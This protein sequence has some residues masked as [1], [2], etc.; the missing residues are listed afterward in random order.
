MSQL[1]V[2]RINDASGGVLAPISS[3]MRNRLINGAMTINQRGGAVTLPS[4]QTYTLDRWFGSEDTDGAMTVEQSTNAPTGFN[5]SALCTTTTA[6]SSLGATQNVYLGQKIEGFN[7]ADL[8]WGT[9]N[10]K[11]VTLSF[12]VRSSLTGAFGG[13][14][15]NSA[16]N[17]SYPFSY[18]ISSAN[19][20]EQKSVTIAGDT[21]GTWV[22]AT[23]GVGIQLI[24]GLGVGSTFSGTA[25]AWAGSGFLS[26]TGAVS[27]IGTLSA[28]WQITGAQLEVGTQATSFEY[29]QY[30]NELQLCQRYA[31]NYRSADAGVYMR[32]GS[33]YANATTNSEI[34]VHFPV[35]MRTTPSLTTTATASNY[36]IY[37]AGGIN[38]CSTLPVIDANSDNPLV[39]TVLGSSATPFTSGAGCSIISNNNTTSYM[40]FTAEL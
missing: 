30:T 14:V 22:G 7:T 28:T 27:V 23:N 1:Q 24:F 39:L 19:T 2:D 10:A 6:D 9:A 21:S 35:Q 11:T 16:F 13:A 26:T 20:W 38:V 4:A 40:L 17:R 5:F 32:Y 12:W 34:N 37:T 29:R 15:T 8:G 3:I 25:G 36:A 18:T 31:I 33:G